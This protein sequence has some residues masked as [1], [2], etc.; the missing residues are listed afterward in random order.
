MECEHVVT[1]TPQQREVAAVLEQTAR[2]LVTHM[3][4][5]FPHVTEWRMFRKWWNGRVLVGADAYAASFHPDSGCLL[6][7]VPN[8]GGR[9]DLLNTRMLLAISRG[10]T[11][12]KACSNSHDTI[13]REASKLGIPYSLTCSDVLEYALP[14][15]APCHQDR[16]SWP[17]YVGMPVDVV[18][19][20]FQKVGR[21]VEVAPWDTM[22]GKPATPNVVRILY[23]TKSRL[24]VSPAPHLGSLHIP[25]HDDQCFLKADYGV[26]CIG[27]PTTGVPA[28]WSDFVGRFFTE[29]VDIL[30]MTYPHATIEPWPST[31]AIPRDH[32][33]DRIRV[34]FNPETAR[35]ES[36]PLV[37]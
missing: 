23:D 8:D 20:A 1:A 29:V 22:Y 26:Q 14:Y 28:Q 2:R 3:R 4:T 24:V 6:V 18:V 21:R 12:G 35:V 27:A 5:T 37:G 7:G 10:A 9:I 36:I 30:R 31:A 25:Q 17:E 33:P 13:L 16:L 19:R 11:N 34:R 15:Q 32:R